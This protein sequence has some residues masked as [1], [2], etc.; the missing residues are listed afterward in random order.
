MVYKAQG[1]HLEHFVI[2]FIDYLVSSTD[3]EAS[4]VR[5]IHNECGSLVCGAHHHSP[6]IQYDGCDDCMIVDVL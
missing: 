4:A 5:A 3:I 6:F 1:G 2:L